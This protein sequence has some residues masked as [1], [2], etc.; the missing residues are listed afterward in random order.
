MIRRG[1][2]PRP[3]EASAGADP[4]ARFGDRFVRQSDHGKGRQPGGDRHLGLDLDDLDPVK[5]NGP[6]LGDHTLPYCKR[7]LSVTVSG[8]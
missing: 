1:G 7:R 6:H 4:L 8:Q 2:S 3:S 5:R